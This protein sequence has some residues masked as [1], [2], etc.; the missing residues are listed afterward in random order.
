MGQKQNHNV[1]YNDL[2]ELLENKFSQLNQIK[3]FMKQKLNDTH[4]DFTRKP[5]KPS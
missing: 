4:T 5:R 2:K 1:I 3:D